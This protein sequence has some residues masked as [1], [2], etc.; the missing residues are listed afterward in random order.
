MNPVNV[1]R[2]LEAALVQQRKSDVI[3]RA[4]DAYRGRT[5][6]Y[7]MAE[8]DIAKVAQGYA[9]GYAEAMRRV[10]SALNEARGR[11]LEC[12]V[13][14]MAGEVCVLRSGHYGAHRGG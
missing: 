6:P 4:F 14:F 3:D 12:G 8:K 1:L 5:L 7:G 10:T 13:E 2:D 11:A 9:E